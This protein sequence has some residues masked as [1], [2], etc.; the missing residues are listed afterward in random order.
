MNPQQAPRQRT[1]RVCVGAPGV[2]PAL[3]PHHYRDSETEVRVLETG[4]RVLENR[5][6]DSESGVRVLETGVLSGITGIR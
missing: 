3:D 2:R 1:G 5:A 4:V 6:R